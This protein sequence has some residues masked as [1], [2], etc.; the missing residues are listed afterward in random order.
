[1]DGQFA[2]LGN[3]AE[4]TLVKVP[5]FQGKHC[6]ARFPTPGFPLGLVYGF[7]IPRACDGKIFNIF[8]IIE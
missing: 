6:L 1:M 4:C 5:E 8:F 2:W 7:C 3:Y